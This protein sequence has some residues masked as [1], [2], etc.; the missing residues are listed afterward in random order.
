[1]T[2]GFDDFVIAGNN[3]FAAAA[4]LAVAERPGTSY[5][6][7]FIYSG[8]GFGKTHL[9][10]VVSKYVLLHCSHLS[11]RFVSYEEFLSDF[12]EASLGSSIPAF[13]KRYGSLDVLLVDDIH[14]LGNEQ[15]FQQVAF[16]VFDS[17]RRN[18]GQ[19]V[20]SANRRPDSIKALEPRLIRLFKSGLVADIQPP[21][22]ETR[23]AISKSMEH[24]AGES[25]PPA[26]VLAFLSAE[27]DQ[28][29]LTPDAA[30]ELLIEHS[31]R[32]GEEI[33]IDLAKRILA[34]YLLRPSSTRINPELI[35]NVVSETFDLTASDLI[36]GSRRRLVVTAR[37]V[38]MYVM[39]E[40]TD[41]T[42]PAIA[43]EFGGRDHT[44]AIYAVKKIGNLM[45]ERSGIFEQVHRIIGRVRRLAGEE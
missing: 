37:Q 20:L 9:L 27:I 42:Y 26:D 43:S 36:G 41:L 34:E 4:A 23:L 10:R 13:R 8:A 35:L 29:M 21:E 25:A 19:I 7:L 31:T 33:S 32:T 12:L 14:Q 11:V 18:N 3:R 6:P 24:D 2:D 22:W 39:R 1:M 16:E 38:A 5:S 28:S 45:A 15:D 17:I 40:L 30:L 44:T